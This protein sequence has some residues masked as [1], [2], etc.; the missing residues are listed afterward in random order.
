MAKL[1]GSIKVCTIGRFCESYKP[2]GILYLCKLEHAAVFLRL[3]Y[4][5]RVFHHQDLINGVFVDKKSISAE[6]SWLEAI[7]RFAGCEGLVDQRGQK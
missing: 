7:V 4:N 5:R 6:S 1:F 3:T 2:H